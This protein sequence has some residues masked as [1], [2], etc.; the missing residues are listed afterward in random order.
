MKEAAGGTV[1]AGAILLRQ[2]GTRLKAGNNVGRGKDDT[3]YA[4]I[5]G[6]VTFERASRTERRVSVYPAPAQT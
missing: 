3:L 5:D 1:R 2:R 4:L 6:I